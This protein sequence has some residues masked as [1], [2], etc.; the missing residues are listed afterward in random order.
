M[1]VEPHRKS[2]NDS[3][4]KNT[5]LFCEGMQRYSD[6]KHIEIPKDVAVVIA[7][8]S[9]LLRKKEI[10]TKFDSF[11]RFNNDGYH[12]MRSD[13]I[14]KRNKF[15]DEHPDMG[16]DD[17]ERF[18]ELYPYNVDLICRQFDIIEPSDLV[19]FTQKQDEILS[20]LL[21]VK[22]QDGILCLSEP[23]LKPFHNNKGYFSLQLSHEDNEQYE[24]L[25]NEFRNKLELEKYPKFVFP[26]SSKISLE[27]KKMD[28]DDIFF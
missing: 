22:K 28:F 17:V 5:I 11:F 7:K 4:F 24:M 14:E 2:E 8:Q 15:I 3:W 6:D 13:W 9:C 1:E 21:F 10:Y 18:W 27:D 25:P 16:D 12:K 19:F 26:K 20:S 23:R